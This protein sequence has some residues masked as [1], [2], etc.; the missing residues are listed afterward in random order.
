MAED[1]S[2]AGVFSQRSK[3]GSPYD[4]IGKLAGL[5]GLLG[6][7]AG[8]FGIFFGVETPLIRLPL[9]EHSIIG[10]EAYFMSSAIFIGLLAVGVFLQMIGSKE[11]RIKLGSSF[12]QIGYVVAILGI[13]MA[14][15]LPY[16]GEN[17]TN[18]TLF[19][20]YVI[21]G[22]VFAAL[23]I[24]FWQMYNTIYTDASKNWIGL[25]ASI[26]NGFFF[27]LLALGFIYGTLLTMIAYIVLIVGQLFV[28][29]F[30]W[31]PLDTV[32]EYARSP[33]MAK[34]TFGVS[35][36]LTFLIGAAGVFANITESEWGLLWTPFSTNTGWNYVYVIAFTSA[37][38]FWVLQGP[39]LGKKEL[40]AA[41]ISDDLIGGGI[42]YFSAFL[43]AVGIYGAMQAGTL[44]AASV[45]AWS[46][47]LVWSTSG[48]MFLVGAIYVGRT[49]IVTGLP[50]L[51]GAIMMSVHPMVIAEFVIYPFI[52][53][54]VTQFLLMIETRLRGFT[55]YS[56][57][58]LTVLSTIG[59]SILFM[60]FMLGAF[61]SGPPALW[62]TNRWFNVALFPNFP[63]AIQAGTVLVLPLLALIVRNT[64]VV[65]YS[66]GRTR[67]NADVV[68]GI[69]MLF[70]FLIPMIAAAFKGIAHQA[71]TAAS[72][73]L[74][75]YAISFVLVLS[76]N[77]NLAGEVEDTGNPLEGM[78]LRMTAIAGIAIGAII[79]LYAISV[80]SAF[81]TALQ[82]A[83]VITLLVILISGLEILLS[84]GWLFAGIRL[85]MLKSGFK[86]TR[87]DKT[88]MA[89]E[90]FVAP[91][92]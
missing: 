39:R 49:D 13:I 76:V 64:T 34:F 12:S 57:P 25:L 36:F 69:T 77:L 33:E 10:S 27:P 80:F 6:L 38:L 9:M 62:P 63:S 45:A 4:P 16:G 56:Q 73:M 44:Y 8:I 72:I 66:H 3:D 24:M 18:I 87:V 42:K 1:F 58:V 53:I 75:L 23:F 79:A 84:I 32:R 91:T 92:Q 90:A 35:G 48:V 21:L 51:V 85:G 31:A 37:L 55:Y 65:G 2:I 54:L 71:L 81:P 29:V 89:E 67:A 47:A 41:H 59:F 82:A 40:K 17:W 46:V 26:L 61:G 22:A 83:N 11:L 78:I 28:L 60:L 52:L 15:F 43:A 30:W 86:F 14:I 74:A 50:L 5:G 88:L 70:A 20:D 7:A 19:Q 68:S